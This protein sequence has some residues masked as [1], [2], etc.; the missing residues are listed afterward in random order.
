MT[1]I[2]LGPLDLALTA[3]LIVA[4]AALSLLLGLGIHKQVTIAAARMVVQLLLVGYALR[5]IFALTSPAL[6]LLAVTLMAIVAVREIAVRPEQRLARAGNYTISLAAV[7]ATTALTAILA[8]VT[9]IR[10]QPWWSPQYAIPLVGIVLG[11]VLNFASLALD[12]VLDAARQRRP[13]IEAQLALGASFAAATRPL[14]RG[15]IRR[16]TLPIIN[17]MSAAGLI[18]LPGIMTGQILAGLDPVEAVK[19]QILLMF[20]LAGS[21]VL[22]GAIIAYL[23]LRRLTDERDRLRLDR[24]M[25]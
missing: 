10:P 17:Q 5:L 23:A 20:L 22:A 13:A 18:T 6:T 25:S 3:S 7:T 4:E 19:Y 21:S 1:P 2:S 14:L 12:H 9:A 24:L 15:A 8:L 11:S 16:G